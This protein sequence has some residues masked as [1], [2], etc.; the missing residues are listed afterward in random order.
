M[1][2]HLGRRVQRDAGEMVPDQPGNRQ[3]LDNNPVH[4]HR[5]QVGEDVHE[6]R[7]LLFLDEGVERY[8]NPSSEGMGIA[9][10]PLQLLQ[11]KIFRLGPGRE[12]FQPCIDGIGAFF[13]RRKEG[14]QGAGRRKKFRFLS[15]L[16]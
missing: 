8:V 2:C 7:E 16:S 10:H 11:G 3:I 6:R 14:L 13:H 1:D 9:E 15:F 5:F 4:S 12:I